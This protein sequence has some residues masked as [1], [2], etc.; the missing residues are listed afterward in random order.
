MGPG[1]LGMHFSSAPLPSVML[2]SP[3][4]W[5]SPGLLPR[6]WGQQTYD[7]C[8]DE[9]REHKQALSRAPGTKWA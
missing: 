6:E 1:N 3:V 2:K 5:L 9:V 4:T 8:N 7:C